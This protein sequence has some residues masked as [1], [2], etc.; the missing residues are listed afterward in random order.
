M[1]RIRHA[2]WMSFLVLAILISGCSGG[3]TAGNG[4]PGTDTPSGEANAK[5][6]VTL[7]LWVTSREQ[8]D[9]TAKQEKAF[10]DSHPHITLNKVVKEGDP[11]NEF[12]QGVAAGNA[13]DLISVSFTMMDKYMKAGILEPLNPYIEQW[14][15]WKN[16]S[17]EYVDM[18][19]VKDQIYGVP[20]AVSPMLFG[21]NKALLEKAGVTEPPATWNDALE[22]AKKVNDPANQV[23]GYATLTAEWTEWFFQ[24]YVWQAGGDLTK[25]NEDGTIELTFTDPAVIEAAEYYKKLRASKVLQSDLTLKFNDLVE[26][27]A[28]GKIAMMPFAGDWVSWAVSLGMDPE[29]IGLSLPPV[30]PSGK[31]VTAIGGS[32]YVINAKTD[33]DK[34]DAAWELI[35]YYMSRDV[36]IEGM[37]NTAS[38]GSANPTGMVREDIKTEDYYKLPEEYYAV[39]EQVKTASRLEFYGKA[40][41]A[42][43]VDRAVQKILIDPNADPLKELQAAQKLAETEIV[44]GFNEKIKNP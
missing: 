39:L 4:T 10:L 19:T 11:G 16:F 40:E 22:I 25:Q 24:Y 1:K 29:D 43:Y 23:A 8:D 12:Y 14:D 41:L 30:G 3:K 42:P 5:K 21:Y 15:E 27:F 28:Q 6:P 31:P 33:Q 2:A 20:S 7:T 18:F 38:K 32:T 26:K 34:K 36:M 17:K 37:K 9:F 35:K 44:K 13:P